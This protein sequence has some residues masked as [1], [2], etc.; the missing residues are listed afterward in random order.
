M[1]KFNTKKAGFMQYFLAET[2]D[3]EFKKLV[4]KSFNVTGFI[5]SIKR[6]WSI[7]NY[8]NGAKI[9]EW[10][11]RYEN[12]H[13]I[14]NFVDGIKSYTITSGGWN[15]PLL[16]DINSKI[17]FI[18]M[19]ETNLNQKRKEI[20]SQDKKYQNSQSWSPPHY[21]VRLSK[22]NKDIAAQLSLDIEENQ[23]KYDILKSI[24][25][26]IDE[27]DVSE[28][29]KLMIVTFKSIGDA[30]VRITAGFYDKNLMEI[31]SEDWSQYITNDYS[32]LLDTRINKNK[33]DD[34]NNKDDL[35]E[36]IDDEDEQSD[37]NQ[38]NN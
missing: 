22:I 5:D 34:I 14:E 38:E 12:I 31:Y 18:F 25:P 29:L 37:E 8:N 17:A 15:L 4:A 20:N 24:C 26:E 30:L 11:L 6:E 1:F 32:A 21:S 9:F 10:M 35:T 27:N 23:T 19:K 7:E 3:P 36:F 16:I 2:I 33:I 28:D 13:K